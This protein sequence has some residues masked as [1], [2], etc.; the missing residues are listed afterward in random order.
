MARSRQLLSPACLVFAAIIQLPLSPITAQTAGLENK[1]GESLD[2][3]VPCFKM[4]AGT[5]GVRGNGL[6]DKISYAH[7][8]SATDPIEGFFFSPLS[9]PP[10]ERVLDYDLLHLRRPIVPATTG[11]N[12][13]PAETQGAGTAFHALNDTH[14]EHPLGDIIGNRVMG[15]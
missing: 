9:P 8:G 2:R 12:G 1:F 10:D 6:C 5:R 7:V 15:W 13:I 14:K 3:V 4:N 11:C